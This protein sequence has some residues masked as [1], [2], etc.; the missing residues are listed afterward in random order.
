M[1]CVSTGVSKSSFGERVPVTTTCE[2]SCP[3]SRESGA[4][5][6]S[7]GDEERKAAKTVKSDVWC[8]I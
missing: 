4:S 6:A 8:I 3:V 7:N 1:T 5:A 2:S